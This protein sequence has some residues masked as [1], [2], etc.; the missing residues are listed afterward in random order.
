MERIE[1]FVGGVGFG[2]LLA[3]I[4]M[5]SFAP[6]AQI[7]APMAA[8]MGTIGL[9]IMIAITVSLELRRRAGR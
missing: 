4:V 5:L 3:G 7:V 2:L 8:V 9:G 6:V 1:I